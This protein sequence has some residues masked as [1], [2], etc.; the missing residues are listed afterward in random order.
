MSSNPESHMI[1][2]CIACYDRYSTR[3][4]KKGDCPKCG[5]SPTGWEAA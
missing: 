1:W 3:D 2:Q 4:R 5:Y